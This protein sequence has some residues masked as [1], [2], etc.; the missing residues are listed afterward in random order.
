[1]LAE[2]PKPANGPVDC[3]TMLVECVPNVSEGRDMA[4]IARLARAMSSSR[5]ALLHHTADPDHNRTVFTVAGAAD[6]VVDAA[7]ALARAVVDEI[8]LAHQQG[9]H[10]RVGALDVVPFV[11]LGRTTLADAV[12]C[13]HRFGQAL[14]Q[15]HGIPVFFYGAAAGDGRSLPAVRRGGLEG[16]AGRIDA[17]T[18]L[19]DHGPRRLHRRAGATA[20][21]AREI[22]IAFN[23]V[24]DREDIDA[25]RRIAARIRSSA[26]GG[27]PAVR[28]IGVGLPSRGLVQVSMN[29]LDH[30]RTTP[31]E[32]YAR[33]VHEAKAE[34][35][36]VVGSEIVGLVPSDALPSEPEAELRLETTVEPLV[37]ERR[38][39]LAGLGSMLG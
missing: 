9:V 14:A 22:L 4:I 17:G 27:L 25:V 23:V 32:A 37:L 38:L 16:L 26:P 7:L 31:L 3:P 20:V 18:M 29:L 8:D 13:A 21:G 24:L 30:H 28:A 15:Q 2:G 12:A 33:V 19:P 34:G 5:A 36:G 10:P 1:M 11:P 6:D 39:D 35:I